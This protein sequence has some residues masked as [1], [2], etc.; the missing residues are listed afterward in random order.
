VVAR[1]FIM[2]VELVLSLFN[3]YLHNTYSKNIKI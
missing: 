3:L 2:L 1:F